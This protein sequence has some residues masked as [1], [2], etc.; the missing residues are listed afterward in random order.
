MKVRELLAHLSAAD[1]EAK[2]LYLDM[3][4][5]ADETDAVQLVDIRPEAWTREKGMCAGETCEARYAGKPAVRDSSYSRIA[6]S[7]LRVV[8]SS[9][10]P[11]NLRSLF[12]LVLGPLTRCQL[13][14]QFREHS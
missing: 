14:L 1:P 8:V 11:T 4:A 7:S 10:G 12:L 2:L 13:V 9:P 6:T 5:D 3:H